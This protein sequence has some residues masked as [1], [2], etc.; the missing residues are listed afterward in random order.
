MLT[1]S[2][3]PRVSDTAAVPAW[4]GRR[5][6]PIES[7]CERYGNDNARGFAT[8]RVATILFEQLRTHHGCGPQWLEPLQAAAVL[9]GIGRGIGRGFGQGRYE[10]HGRNIVLGHG[11]AGFDGDLS[12][13]IADAI[14]LHRGPVLAEAELL[15]D[16]LPSDM[17]RPSLLVAAMLRI[18]VCLADE[19]AELGFLDDTRT[20]LRW[21]V[22]SGPAAALATEAAGL[23]DEVAPRP[24]LFRYGGS[25]Q[26]AARGSDGLQAAGYRMALGLIGAIGE[27]RDKVAPGAAIEEL[28]QFR[29]ASRRLRAVLRATRPAFGRDA[30]APLNDAVRDMTRETNAVR[31]LDVMLEAF[32]GFSA[33][34]R[35]P[36]L[37]RH[38]L[39]DREDR[40]RD[41][42]AAL[43]GDAFERFQAKADAFLADFHPQRHPIAS[44]W[45]RRRV[46]DAAPELVERGMRR[47]LAHQEGVAA[48]VEESLHDLR[49]NCKR[50]RYTA[51]LLGAGVEGVKR[52]VVRP[53]KA[54]QESL[55]DW[56]DADVHGAYVARYAEAGD[57]DARD[58]G[59]LRD[60]VEENARKKR[61]ALQTFHA[62]WSE[63]ATRTSPDVEPAGFPAG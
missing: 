6:R 28:H 51:E 22:S 7:L 58:P 17:R 38:M 27:R 61:R 52:G 33:P 43:R 59:A 2:G 19:G 13:V 4:F 62:Q 54:M 49:L 36:D 1:P 26:H 35:A 14:L 50:L 9:H 15:G 29:V 34:R 56:N 37:W 46:R 39:A 42:H 16:A 45:A 44:K 25:K 55:G 21:H 11:L 12:H 53:V 60:I 40:E 63:F 48:G 20:T 57:R 47:V 23:W 32:Q 3:A 24:L 8:S 18:A 10:M 5:P 30:L 31:D 41:M